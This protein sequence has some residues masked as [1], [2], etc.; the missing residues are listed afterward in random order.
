VYRDGTRPRLTG[1]VGGNTVLP[2]DACDTLPRMNALTAPVFSIVMPTFNRR[3]TVVESIRALSRQTFADGFEVIAVVD[4]SNDGSAE[5]L[6]SLNVPFS[7]KVIEQPNAGASSAR[8]RGAREATGEFILFLDD[9]MVADPE[10]LVQH[11]ASYR[12][13]ADAVLGHL[14]LHPESPRNFLSKG[15]GKWAEHRT[16]KLLA[17][18]QLTLMDLL[19]GQ[20]SVRRELFEALGGFDA[21]FTRDGSF[22]AEDTD[23]GWRL[24]RSGSRVVFN[25]D[26]ISHQRYVVTFRHFLRQWYEA[27]KADAVLARKHPEIAADLLE[28]HKAHWRRNRVVLRPL[29]G[30]PVLGKIAMN[31][32]R[33]AACAMAERWPANDR[34]SR[35]FGRTRDFVYWRGLAEGGGIRFGRSLRVLAYH[36]VSKAV[37]APKLADY[38]IDPKDFE[39]QFDLLHRKGFN[40]VSARQAAAFLRGEGLLPRR[41]VLVTFDDGYANLKEEA[42]PILQ[43]WRIPAV[44]FVVTGML[45]RTN[46]WDRKHDPTPKRLMSEEDLRTLRELGIEI[47]A[48][49]RHH[50]SLPKLSAADLAE[51]VDGSLAD[52][53]DHRLSDLGLFCYPYGAV[54]DVVEER[55]RTAGARAAFTVEAG[56]AR[57]GGNPMRVPRLEILRSD[58]CGRRFL[59]KVLTAGSLRSVLA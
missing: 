21:D 19:T 59:W 37:G 25:P 9:D 11:Q 34:V 15:V 3:D 54:N 2:C 40:F 5:A 26:A 57:S 22:G 14:P 36:S 6:R 42:A 23:F 12:A 32:A 29:A 47:G 45:G 10:L 18:T 35:L 20:L 33:A 24:L 55:L 56:I 17:G 38:V 46:E 27:G 48:H 39:L 58:G 44:V 7:F 13:G 52:L 50:R 28:L 43:K 49:S 41:A 4:G 31:V 8:N 16:Q 1:F 53:V 51:E 30:M